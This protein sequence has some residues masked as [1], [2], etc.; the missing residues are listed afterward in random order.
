MGSTR[1]RGEAGVMLDGEVKPQLAPN[2]IIS[3]WMDWQAGDRDPALAALCELG[4]ESRAEAGCVDY[5]MCADPGNPDRIRVFEHWT[6]E[7][8]LRF[9]LDTPHV[10]RF[11]ESTRQLNRAGRSLQRHILSET[12]SF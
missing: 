9:H 1:D 8:A 10:A 4:K 2:V 6:S 3:G 5:V 7:E 11:R 12:E